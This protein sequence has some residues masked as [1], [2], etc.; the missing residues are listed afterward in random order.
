LQDGGEEIYRR[1]RGFESGLLARRVRRARIAFARPALAV[2][3]ESFAAEIKCET[4]AITPP[5]KFGQCPAP[6]TTTVLPSN[7]ICITPCA[8]N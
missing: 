2:T 6:L 1:D 7:L 4:I 5:G 8:E 3:S